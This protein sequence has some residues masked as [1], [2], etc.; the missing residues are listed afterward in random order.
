LKKILTILLTAVICLAFVIEP[1][2]VEYDVPPPVF[3]PVSVSPALSGEAVSIPGPG[4][5]DSEEPAAEEEPAVFSYGPLPEEIRLLIS[6]CSWQEDAPV[7]LDEL[8]YL[9]ITHYTLEGGVARGELIVNSLL[10]EEVTE[11]FKE[12]YLAE[13]PIAKM[14]LVDHYGG[15]DDLSMADNNTYSFCYRTISGSAILSQHSYGASI[16]INPL[17][18]PYLRKGTAYPEEAAAYKDRGHVRT[19]MITEGDACYN[20][21]V[22]RGWEWGGHWV[23]P[24]DYQHFQKNIE[25]FK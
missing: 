10:A 15:S 11:I 17:Q 6:G 2:T 20:A 14:E 5:A 9:T 18:N 21:F 23:E 8:S 12:L 13:Y 3:E 25:V 19:G 7:T 4:L 24:I 22:S 1:A 16:D